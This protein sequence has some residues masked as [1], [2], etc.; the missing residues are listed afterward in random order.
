MTP[1]TIPLQVTITD[2]SPHTALDEGGNC[3]TLELST[4]PELSK[5]EEWWTRHMSGSAFLDDD[6]QELDI[7]PTEAEII[8]I[9]DATDRFL[10][11]YHK[12]WQAHRIDEKVNEVL[13]A[14][15]AEAGKQRY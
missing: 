5:Y 7:Q 11:A 13:R 6:N 9:T 12:H 1:N 15:R 10:E 2:Y 4:R 8:A 14:A 3:F